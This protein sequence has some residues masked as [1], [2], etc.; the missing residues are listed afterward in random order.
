MIILL[1]AVS[2]V[3]AFVLVYLFEFGW[4]NRSV[5]M[6]IQWPKS[7]AMR[8]MWAVAGILAVVGQIPF[9]IMSAIAGLP[10]CL[11]HLRLVDRQSVK[12]IEVSAVAD[13]LF[14]TAR[15]FV[16]HFMDRMQIGPH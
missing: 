10:V 13:H 4:T 9:G 3:C 5:A 2:V 14:Q 12:R 1:M 8:F 16:R 6:A 11:A 7:R 15:S